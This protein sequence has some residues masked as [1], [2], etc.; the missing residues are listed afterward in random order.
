MLVQNKNFL[1]VNGDYDEDNDENDF[2]LSILSTN[3]FS[4]IRKIQSP[5][6]TSGIV[7]EDCLVLGFTHITD[8]GVVTRFNLNS[9]KEEGSY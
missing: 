6:L 3:D 2:T 7:D 8:D 4:I 1:I 9:L 5:Y